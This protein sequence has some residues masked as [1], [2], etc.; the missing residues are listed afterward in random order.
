MGNDTLYLKIESK[1]YEDL[2][3]FLK[4]TQKDKKNVLKNYQ[5]IEQSVYDGALQSLANILK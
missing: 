1:Y 4:S 5:E 3:L 2:M